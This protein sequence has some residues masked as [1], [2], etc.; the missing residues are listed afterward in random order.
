MLRNLDDVRD[1]DEFLKER[2]AQFRHKLRDWL[3]PHPLTIREIR[4]H[5]VLIP[6][7]GV[8]TPG[9][10]VLPAFSWSF[11]ELRTREGLIGTGE[12]S[13]DLP[14]QTRE[15]IA[16]LEAN[17][18]AN[19]LEPQWEEPLFMA[20]WDLVGQVLGKPLHLLW[21]ELFERAFTPP[22]RVPTAAYSWNRFA[23]ANGEGE[24]N[25]ENWPGHAAERVHQGFKAIKVSMTGYQPVDYIDLVH[26]I[27][28]AIGPDIALRIDAHGTWN[29]QEAR[30]I[31][32]QVEDCNL[33]YIEQPVNSLLPQRYY[34]AGM[35]APSRAHGY[36]SE[37]YFRRMTE[38]RGRLS[39][40]LSC[41]WWTPPLV[42]PPGQTMMSCAWEPDWYLMERY[43]A[44]DVS[45][46]DI[47]LGVWGLW[48]MAQLARFLGMHIAVHSNFELCLQLAFRAAMV[49]ALVYEDDGAGLYLGATPRTCHAIDNETIQVK[50]DV[51]EGGQFGWDGGEVPLSN[52]AGHGLKLD[53]ERLRAFEYNEVAIAPHR[54]FAQKIY[55]DYRVDRAWRVGQS[56]WPISTQDAQ[57]KRRAYPYD[58]GKILGADPTQQIDVELNM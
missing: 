8:Y 5:R 7:H 6:M 48:R 32:P 12:F 58:V 18:H 44:A 22:A 27:R 56:G 42:L 33:E 26:R 13:V 40:P 45:V 11:V 21:A 38:L 41:H 2:I 55:A 10:Q 39:T 30:Q 23:D 35:A 14:A 28:A 49:A 43:E 52:K 25:Y 34:P 51:I 36:Q 15:A 47:G 4:V 20:W 46:P 1:F 57:L 53:A 16:F 50:D 19:I 17:P 3:A 31:L 54:A 24:V 9:K 37:Y 29:Y